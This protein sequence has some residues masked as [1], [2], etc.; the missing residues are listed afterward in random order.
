MSRVLGET[1]PH[2]AT[3]KRWYNEFE[4]GRGSLEDEPHT[5][6]IP[7]STS[8]E[9]VK[10]VRALIE[11]DPQTTYLQIQ[12]QLKIGSSSV[13]N[14]LHE[15]LGVS[16]SRPPFSIPRTKTASAGNMQRKSQDL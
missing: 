2:L 8:D 15:K 9:M 14:I 13:H 12:Q 4:R 3:I 11:E 1:S 6:R 5:G 16:S 10:K 7:S